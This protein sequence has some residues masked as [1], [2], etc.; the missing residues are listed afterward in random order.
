MG[1]TAER[2][3]E[4]YNCLSNIEQS[5]TSGSLTDS[6]VVESVLVD[7]LILLFEK[8]PAADRQRHLDSVRP[9]LERIDR[10]NEVTK[11]LE[12]LANSGNH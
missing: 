8:L 3:F 2:E 5:Y 1:E 6:R 7:D 11:K 10:R 12:K 9:R 4:F